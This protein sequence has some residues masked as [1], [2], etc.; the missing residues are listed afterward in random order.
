MH[1]VWEGRKHEWGRGVDGAE[2]RADEACP[3]VYLRIIVGGEP[4]SIREIAFVAPI[5]FKRRS[6][7]PLLVHADQK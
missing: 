7:V 1:R 6:D 5:V 2:I 4:H 3:A